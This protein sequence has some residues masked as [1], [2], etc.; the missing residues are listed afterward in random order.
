[1]LLEMELLLLGWSWICCFGG[2]LKLRP[3]SAERKVA[4]KRQADVTSPW[5][6]LFLPVLVVARVPL[7]LLAAVGF[8]FDSPRALY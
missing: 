8:C 2:S 5:W 7:V 6:F 3:A 4:R 1:L